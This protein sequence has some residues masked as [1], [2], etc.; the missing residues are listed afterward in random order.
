MGNSERFPSGICLPFLPSHSVC[1]TRLAHWLNF[2]TV[3]LAPLLIT[4]KTAAILPMSSILSPLQ[5]ASPPATRSHLL[6]P[7]WPS[8][9]QAAAAQPPPWWSCSSPPGTTVAATIVVTLTPS[10]LII[11]KATGQAIGWTDTLTAQATTQATLTPLGS[12]PGRATG[13]MVKA[14]EAAQ[15]STILRW[16][17][18][19]SLKAVVAATQAAKDWRFRAFQEELELSLDNNGEALAPST[20]QKT[21]AWRPVA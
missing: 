3:Y 10:G 9:S 7:P 15:V 4:L 12:T 8:C 13:P 2:T 1:C 6:S 20:P 18:A 11:G 5:K 14:K 17:M 21:A 19:R 16:T